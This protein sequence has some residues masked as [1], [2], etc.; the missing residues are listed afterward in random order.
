MKYYA[1]AE[2][3]ELTKSQ[4]YIPKDTIRKKFQ[5]KHFS[6]VMCSFFILLPDIMFGDVAPLCLNLT[7]I[8]VLKRSLLKSD[9]LKISRSHR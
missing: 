7:A 9:D 1:M 2:Q 4:T 3:F 6:L 8:M 5:T